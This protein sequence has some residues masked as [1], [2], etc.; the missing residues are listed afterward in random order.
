MN[1]INPLYILAAFSLM[2]LFMVYESGV[3]EKKIV[4]T[5]QENARMEMLGKKIASLKER[6]KDL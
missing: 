2:A 4:R 1:K 3:M 5:A 6:W